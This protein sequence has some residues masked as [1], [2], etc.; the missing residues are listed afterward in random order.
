MTRKPI[1][2]EIQELRVLPVPELVERYELVFG[3]P[4][5]VKHRDWLWR[6]VAWKV[7]EQRF[8]GLST[9][10]RRRLDELIDQLD[11]PLHGERTVRVRLGAPRRGGEPPVGTRVSRMWR[12]QE[13]VAVAVEGGW[14]HEGVVYRSLSGIAKAVTGAHWNGRL[15][16]GLTTRKAKS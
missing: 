11:V 15:F 1:A 2:E 16:F 9:V 12:G 10:A 3:K 5:R 4:P 7:Q 8:G 14:E 13:V 6:R